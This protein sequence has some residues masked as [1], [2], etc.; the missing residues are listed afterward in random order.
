VSKFR[1]IW[2]FKLPNGATYP[3]RA[4]PPDPDGRYLPMFKTELGPAYEYILHSARIV[5]YMMHF[6][7][8]R[9]VPC[10]KTAGIDCEFCGPKT[11]RRWFGYL[12][13]YSLRAKQ[14][15]IITITHNCI[16]HVPTLKK[17][18]YDLTGRKLHL[19][20][21]GRH[22]RGQVMARL[23][24]AGVHPVE[25]GAIMS[26]WDLQAQ[27]FWIWGIRVKLEEEQ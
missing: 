1:K 3:M 10:F 25:E 26:D 6:V 9:N 8:Q 16:K 23:D 15:G 27:L 4:A 20:R 22:K 18:G 17:E 11:S 13:G 19:W 24:L 14:R 2:E 7:D 21:T 5:S 12:V